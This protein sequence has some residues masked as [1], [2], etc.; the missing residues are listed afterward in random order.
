MESGGH[1][2]KESIDRPEQVIDEV[3]TGR[4]YECVFCKQGFTTAQALGGHMNIHRRERARNR[5]PTIPSASV[6]PMEDYSRPAHSRQISNHLPRNSQAE[7]TPG[8]YHMYLPPSSSSTRHR[9][10]GG[11][12]Q[13]GSK[14]TFSLYEE[15]QY[16]NLSLQIGSTVIDNKEEGKMQYGEDDEV[17]LEL[18]LGHDP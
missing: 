14:R 16:T 18:R 13:L 8:N 3:S 15:D 1:D 9:R 10:R 2:D 12:D 4:Y 6:E 17:D 7:E 11:T 5:Q